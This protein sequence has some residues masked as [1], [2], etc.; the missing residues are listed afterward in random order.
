VVVRALGLERLSALVG[1]LH[2]G[3]LAIAVERPPPAS[4]HALA[5]GA[6]GIGLRGTL[7]SDSTRM[8]GFVLSTDIAPTILDRLRLPV[9]DEV[10]GEPIHS[11]GAAD[12]SHVARLGDRLAV[13]GPRRGTVI[14]A[15]LAIWAATVALAAIAFGARGLRAGLPL[16]AVAVA[17]LPAALLLTA[18]LEPSALAEWLVAGLGAPALA[19]ATLRLV[20]AWGAIAIAGAVTVVAYALEVIAG[21]GLT[22][23]S[24]M[25]PNP[26]GGVRFFGIGNELEAT[27]AALVP[28]ATGAALAAWA[29]RVPPPRAAAAFAL[30]GLG[31]VA[32]FAPGSFGADVGAAISIPIGVGAAIAACLGGARR[33]LLLAVAVPI[34]ALA[35]LAAVDVV[36]GGDAHLSRSVLQ[37]GGL[38]ELGDVAE[39]RLR[40]SATNFDRYAASPVMWAALLA[41]VVGIWQRRRIEAWFGNRRVAWAGFLGGAAATLAGTLAN[42]SGALFLMIGTALVAVTAGIA[43]ATPAER[44]YVP[45]SRGRVR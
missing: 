19:L 43:W 25:G 14:G 6:A 27:V 28:I 17:Y 20:S 21:P 42:D 44:A 12:P 26:V 3:D 13:I 11:D 18:A 22:E 37:A 40:L 23:L 35:A 5:F 10:S 38:D 1:R 30:A 31:A 29:P 7:T 24:L 32:A 16:L 39:R 2:R 45:Q 4:E 33:G 9:P 8:R 34:V 36:L 41:I 15:T